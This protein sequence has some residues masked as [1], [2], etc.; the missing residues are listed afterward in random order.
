[1]IDKIDSLLVDLAK[2]NLRN[3]SQLLMLLELGRNQFAT[4]KI[5]AKAG[6][7]TTAATTGAVDVMEK[8]GLVTR[9]QGLDR[10]VFIV[11]LSD[12]GEAFMSKHGLLES[13]PA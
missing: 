1:M 7:V 11:E 5:L 4:M 3:T 6:K 12:K 8:A 9:R 2:M 10:R 13:V